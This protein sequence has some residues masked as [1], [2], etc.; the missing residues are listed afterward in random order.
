MAQVTRDGCRVREQ[1]NALAGEGAAEGWFFDP[2]VDAVFQV[3]FSVVRAK[4]PSFPRRRESSDFEGE[5]MDSRLRGTDKCF[6]EY[7][8]KNSKQDWISI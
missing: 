8:I 3:L 5:P 1:G 7:S 6:F 2:A 4:F